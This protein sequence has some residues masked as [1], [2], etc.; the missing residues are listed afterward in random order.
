MKSLKFLIVGLCLLLSSCG[1]VTYFGDRL[2]PTSSVDIYYS[3]HDVKKDYTVI[4]HLSFVNYLQDDQEHIKARLSA[5]AKQVGADGI[6][7][8]GTTAVEDAADG[9]VKADALKYK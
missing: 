7:I 8:Q 4:G 3:A 2:A 1:T 6:I 5:Y 9:I